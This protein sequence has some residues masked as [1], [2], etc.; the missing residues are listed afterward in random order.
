VL[1]IE[2]GL[3]RTGRG[4]IRLEDDVLVTDDGPVLLSHLPLELRSIPAEGRS[5][6]EEEHR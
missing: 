2:P 1:T 3:Y 6:H 4:G 5:T